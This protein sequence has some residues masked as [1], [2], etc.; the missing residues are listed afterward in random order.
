MAGRE[1]ALP[2]TA[3]STPPIRMGRILLTN[4]SSS[5]VLAGTFWTTLSKVRWSSFSYKKEKIQKN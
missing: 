4:R 1:D 5:T 2:S 3:V